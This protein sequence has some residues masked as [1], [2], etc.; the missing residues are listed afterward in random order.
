MHL[1]KELTWPT[2]IASLPAMEGTNSLAAAS[3]L[4]PAVVIK[5]NSLRADVGVAQAKPLLFQSLFARERC[6]LALEP[7][8]PIEMVAIRQRRL[9]KE[10]TNRPPPKSRDVVL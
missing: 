8:F 6:Y 4:E 5:Q 10:Y 2:P 3:P 7:I 9:S 1:L